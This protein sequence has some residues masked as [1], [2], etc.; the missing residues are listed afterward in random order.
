MGELASAAAATPTGLEG[1]SL[2]V[3][4]YS[5][6]RRNSAKDHCSAFAATGPATLVSILAEDFAFCWMKI[7][8]PAGGDG[9][10]FRPA[11]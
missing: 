10:Q 2:D 6:P 8:P 11:G 3:P 1:L 9:L 7:P 5:D 4:P